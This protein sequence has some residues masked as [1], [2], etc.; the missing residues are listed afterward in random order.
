MT[1]PADCGPSLLQCMRQLLA[2]SQC[3]R[4]LEASHR[5][6]HH[7]GSIAATIG[8]ME[9]RERLI[10]EVCA[11]LNLSLLRIFGHSS[12]R[13]PCVWLAAREQKFVQA[14]HVYSCCR[15]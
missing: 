7:A 14:L 6:H 3:C 8:D 12:G 15:G 11:G 10:T 9:V 4:P 2:P 13:R 5:S 1:V